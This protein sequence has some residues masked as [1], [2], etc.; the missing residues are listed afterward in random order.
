MGIKKQLRKKYFPSWVLSLCLIG[1]FSG[2]TTVD[3]TNN[4]IKVLT[5]SFVPNTGF[6]EQP[7]Q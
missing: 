7:D 5:V 2:C 4:G 6:I 1:V 3:S